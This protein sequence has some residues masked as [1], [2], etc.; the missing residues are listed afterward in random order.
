[1]DEDLEEQLAEALAKADEELKG[2]L[3]SL[4]AALE[5]NDLAKA[6]TLADKAIGMLAPEA[7]SPPEAE[8]AKTFVN[9]LGELAKAIEAENADQIWESWYA[10]EGLDRLKAVAA[11]AEREE[12]EKE[13]AKR[14]SASGIEPKPGGSLTRPGNRADVPDANESWADWTNYRYP[15]VP[16]IR[17]RNAVTRFNDTGNKAAGG[18]SD[19]EWALMGRRIAKV[20][21]EEHSYDAE[22]QQ[23]IGPTRRAA[24]EAE[25]KQAWQDNVARI[26]DNAKA[27]KFV[28]A[29]RGIEA[30]LEEQPFGLP[31]LKRALGEAQRACVAED[32]DKA[33][34]AL[35]SAQ[36]LLKGEKALI[37]D[38]EEVE[39]TEKTLD[40]RVTLFHLEFKEDT[41]EDDRWLFIEG[42]ASTGVTD[43]VGDNIFPNAFQRGLEAY[44]KNPVVLLFHDLKKPIGKIVEAK[45]DEAGLWVRAAIDKTL[46]HGKKA[47]KMIRDGI[48]NAFSVRAVDD[49]AEGW[50]DANG[51]RQITNWD[52]REISAV[53]VPANQQAL[54]SMAK[55]LELGSDLIDIETEQGLFIGGMKVEENMEEKKEITLDE[56]TEKVSEG[57]VGQVIEALAAKKKAEQEAAQAEQ[58]RVDVIKKAA[59][60]E[61]QAE[62]QSKVTKGEKLPFEHP[63][64]PEPQGTIYVASKF[65]RVPTGDL[66]IGYMLMQAMGQPISELYHKALTARAG[67]LHKEGKI[68]YGALWDPETS[69]AARQQ[70]GIKELME[71]A[72]KAAI[73][74]TTTAGVGGNWVPTLASAELWREI[75]LEAKVLPLFDQFDMPSDPYD[76]PS[77]STDPT[78]YK[79]AETAADTSMVF[80]ASHPV[81]ASTIATTK[82]TFDAGK[83][84]ARTHWSTELD[85]DS[86]IAIQPQFR[87]QFGIKMAH[88]IDEVLISGDET[89]GTSTLNISRRGGTAGTTNVILTIDGL[90]HEP[91]FNTTADAT[92]GGVLT[93]DDFVTARSLMGTAGKYAVDPAQLVYICDPG[94]WYQA[95]KLDEV[96]TVDV[97]GTQATILKGQLGSVMGIPLVVS[98]DYGLTSALG[99]ITKAG[100]DTKGSFLCVNR[101]GW[102]V[103]WRRRPRVIVKAYPEFDAFLVLA[104]VRF[105]IEPL[106]TEMCTVVYN[107]TV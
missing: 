21:G 12:L 101:R 16:L 29:L 7:E 76:Y 95:V 49:L 11:K 86:I 99:Y 78:F 20:N 5:D 10:L 85:E 106:H 91:L 96:L 67:K 64:P 9:S 97:I 36:E 44:M 103:G 34:V 38:T 45:V 22:N 90:R 24:E 25:G 31:G 61:Y 40:R 17:A 72:S 63:A 74:E 107:V 33:V 57:V 3:Q 71:V 104:L 87:D 41:S 73:N 37:Q 62:L 42:H 43:R 98:E 6:R 30:M 51:V 77:E 84:G 68:D 80:G 83:L 46:E 23:V 2:V 4:K 88:T 70:V 66:A 53:T 75:R 39:T 13:Q 52:L 18:Y 47:A 27:G 94:V 8:G 89:S 14:A 54:F 26:L 1:M 15:L 48:L 55:A 102:K 60:E 100:G 82:V 28:E 81:A 79:V 50:I 105:D 32:S 92:A 58:E 35:E 56:L 93:I 59:V 19:E 69:Q 65:D